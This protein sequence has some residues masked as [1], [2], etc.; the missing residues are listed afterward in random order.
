MN[1]IKTNITRKLLIFCV[2]A[3]CLITLPGAYADDTAGRSLNI[4]NHI[5]TQSE[6]NSVDGGTFVS[7]ATSTYDTY[8]YTH[9]D[10]LIFSYTDSTQFEVYNSASSLVWSGTV[11]AGGHKGLTYS[12]GISAGTYKIKGTNPYSVLIGDELTSYVMGYYAFD[13][14]GKGLSTKFYTY[15][16]D[17]SSWTGNDYRNFTVFAYED[18]TSV[19]ISNSQTGVAI[20]S[21]N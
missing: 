1:T 11:N 20:W 2:L 5:T 6:F 13:K 10:I 4:A 16:V 3:F 17:T 8:T 14:D 7:T 19:V 21:G 12:D 9:S 15:Q 18:S